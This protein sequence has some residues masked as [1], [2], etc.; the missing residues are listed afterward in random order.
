MTAQSREQQIEEVYDVLQKIS[1]RILAIYQNT[2][3]LSIEVKKDRSPVTQADTISSRM[4]LDH[5]SRDDYSIISEET[6]KRTGKNTDNIWIIDPLD[7]TSDFITKNGEFCIMVGLVEKG[8]PI[9]GVIYCPVTHIGYHAHK[10]HGAYKRS[11]DGKTKQMF[12]SK[13]NIIHDMNIVSSR[14]HHLP[15]DDAVLEKLGVNKSILMGSLGLKVGMI[16]EQ[17]AD[18]YINTS[19]KTSIW[20]TAAPEIIVREAG[21]TMTDIY[22]RRLVYNDTSSTHN[23]HGVVVSNNTIHKQIVDIIQASL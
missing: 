16:V 11:P 10:G 19:D 13:K 4:L 2:A 9:L 3:P 7:G 17:K 21:G 14:S 20:D 15:S 1:F 8:V 6:G 18:I 12:V 22:G 23:H 5:F